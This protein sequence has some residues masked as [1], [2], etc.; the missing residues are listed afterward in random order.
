M[1]DLLV[2]DEDNPHSVAFQAQ[3]AGR[4]LGRLQQSLGGGA[5]EAGAPFTDDLELLLARLRSVN[6]SRF[7]GDVCGDCIGCNACEDLAA[8]LWALAAAVRELSDRLAMRY[9]THVGDVSHQT[10]AA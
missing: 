10:V 7:Q 5:G 2:L 4:Y 3:V 9:F 8:V 1:I 6:L